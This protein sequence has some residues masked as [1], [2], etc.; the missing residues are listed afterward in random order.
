MVALIVEKANKVTPKPKLHEIFYISIFQ[1]AKTIANTTE[2][3]CIDFIIFAVFTFC[4]MPKTYKHERER[5]DGI[6]RFNFRKRA[7]LK[8]GGV[9]SSQVPYIY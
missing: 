8:Y 6:A 9:M 3:L 1:C 5:D 2:K 4:C 7:A